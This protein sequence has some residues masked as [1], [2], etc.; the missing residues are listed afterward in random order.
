MHG[1]F[2]PTASMVS[3]SHADDSQHHRHWTMKTATASLSKR[4]LR[5][6]TYRRANQVMTI[7]PKRKDLAN[8][9]EE[10]GDSGFQP[11]KHHLS[12][13]ILY[14]RLI[15]FYHESFASESPIRSTRALNFC[16]CLEVWIRRRPTP[17]SRRGRP[18]P[19]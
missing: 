12:N 2:E 17:E 9:S 13:N 7:N 5:A 19:P 11:A 18:W 4:V 3:E 8:G 10:T 6:S 1:G 16:C 14:S 15:L